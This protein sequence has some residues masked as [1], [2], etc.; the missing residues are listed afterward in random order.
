MGMRFSTA[1]IVSL[2]LL[3]LVACGSGGGGGGSGTAPVVS[4]ITLYHPSG[5]K[6]AEGPGYRT[7]GDV[8]VRH[9]AWTDWFESGV[10]QM[11]GTYVDG[12]LSDSLA[13]VEYNA[14]SSVRFDWQDY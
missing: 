2:V 8:V 3:V 9:G 14:D 4:I 12:K 1:I 7:D 6:R 10:V 5:A 13:W 11:T